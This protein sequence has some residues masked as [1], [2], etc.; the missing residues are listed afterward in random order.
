MLNSGFNL[1]ILVSFSE[2]TLLT[3]SSDD[4]RL[5]ALRDEVFPRERLSSRRFGLQG[6][7]SGVP[8]LDNCIGSPATRG[9]TACSLLYARVVYY[10]D[11]SALGRFFFGLL[12]LAFVFSE[13]GRLGA[14]LFDAGF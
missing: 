10:L 14:T 6:V 5:I 1:A 11:C 8:L 12:P 13:E 4:P 3:S 9:D 2:S 7:A